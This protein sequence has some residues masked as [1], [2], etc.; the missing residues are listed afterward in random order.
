MANSRFYYY[1]VQGGTL[2]AIDVS[3]GPNQLDEWTPRVRVDATQGNGSPVSVVGPAS[4]RV[5]IGFLN[6]SYLGTSDRALY[7][8][9][10]NLLTHLRQGK[11]VGF[12]LNH[13]KTWAG[14]AL[15][16][17]ARGTT[18]IRTNGNVLSAWSASGTPASGDPLRIES[19]NPVGLS[20]E[21]ALS[22]ALSAGAATISSGAVY[23]HS[24][25]RVLVRYAYCWPALYLPADQAEEPILTLDGGR[26]WTFRATLAVDPAI[27]SAGAAEGAGAGLAL[28]TSSA[29]PG[30]SLDGILN[31][32]AG[33]SGT[34][35]W[36][37]RR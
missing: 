7:R 25:A 4:G 24:G 10:S 29:G 20:E 15:H 14:Y 28:A 35:D 34:S 12:S 11:R 9:L 1:P 31:G 30:V 2:E 32:S 6:R 26:V 23:D 19:A 27:W 16:S 17:V 5:T 13:S 36:W 22:G 8:Y 37:V 21:Q 18:T 33:L 3:P